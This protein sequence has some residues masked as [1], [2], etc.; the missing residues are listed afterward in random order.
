MNRIEE[1]ANPFQDTVA[2]HNIEIIIRHDGLVTWINV[3]G[4]CK[5]RIIGNG[6][7]VPIIIEDQR[8]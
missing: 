6:L 3:D 4:I 1:L 2:K 7:T 5:M 8:K